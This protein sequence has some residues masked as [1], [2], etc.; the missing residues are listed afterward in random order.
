MGW[1]YDGKWGT[2]TSAA[3]DCQM[4][5]RQAC[6]GMTSICFGKW[7]SETLICLIVLNKAMEN[8]LCWGRRNHNMLLIRNTEKWRHQ[9]ISLFLWVPHS[10]QCMS[11]L[12]SHFLSWQNTVPQWGGRQSRTGLCFKHGVLGEEK[13][14]L[15]GSWSAI[16]ERLLSDRNEKLWVK[17]RT[18]SKE[19][20]PELE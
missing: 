10:S 5:P 7:A 18:A 3:L 4:T 12:T 2:C 14:L 11:L 17:S 1:A 13:A 19:E 16:G 6:L 8:L 9:K 20:K 15:V